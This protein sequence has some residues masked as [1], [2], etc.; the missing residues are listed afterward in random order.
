MVALESSS[1]LFHDLH[2]VLVP[3]E[4]RHL[5]SGQDAG[6]FPEEALVRDPGV[7]EEEDHVRIFRAHR[8]QELLHGVM[9]LV[10][11]I[12]FRDLNLAELVPSMTY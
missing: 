2:L 5:S 12:P 6:D 3:V 1:A 4:V 10:R 8:H 11:S 9:L 7:G